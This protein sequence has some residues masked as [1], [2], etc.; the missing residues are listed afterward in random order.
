MT[1]T[2]VTYKTVSINLTHVQQEFQKDRR[3]EKK[4]KKQS[5]NTSQEFSKLCPKLQ[6]TD[7][8][9]QEIPSRINTKVH[10]A[11]PWSMF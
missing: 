5:R 4:A 3:E 10:W 7:P 2:L 11:T 8:G 6:H 1:S 9:A